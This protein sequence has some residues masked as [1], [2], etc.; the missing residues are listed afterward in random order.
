MTQ[1]RWGEPLG[2]GIAA[3]A[4]AGL[5]AGDWNDR[6]PSVPHSTDAEPPWLGTQRGKRKKMKLC[7]V[8]GDVTDILR[9]QQ[10]W[11]DGAASLPPS[12]RDGWA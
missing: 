12:P 1:G 8:E 3:V 6:R 5:A 11:Q 9:R 10:T 4:A 7:Y 2:T